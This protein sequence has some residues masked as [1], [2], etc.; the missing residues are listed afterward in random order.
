MVGLLVL[1]ILKSNSMKYVK[2]RLANVPGCKD[3]V[4]ESWHLVIDNADDLFK[5]CKLDTDLYA[6]AYL[7]VERTSNPNW[8]FDSAHNGDARGAN[9]A[10]MLSCKALSTKEGDQFYPIVEVAVFCDKKA[11]AMLKYL[12]QYGSIQINE[13]GGYCGYDSFVNIWK[14]EVIQTIEKDDV[15]FPIEQKA[16]T[17][18][19]IIL[20]NQSE[21]YTKF[22]EKVAAITSTIPAIINNLK[23][24]DL[25]WIIKSIRASKTIAFESQFRDAEQLDKFMQLFST[26][27]EKHL[28]IGCSD[29]NKS[30]VTDH[31]LF[32]KN[33]AI[34]NI[35]FIDI[36]K[37]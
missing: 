34:H 1:K 27:P 11:Q 31:P 5:Y 32:N 23:E 14:A 36:S 26:L 37:L 33:K 4:M 25:N 12:L 17:A 10:T 30:I 9:V 8:P 21:V 35:E 24:K 15:G 16:L 20:E 6:Q 3:G 2:L 13:S 29:Y 7:Q 28:I 22:S 19:T 18:S